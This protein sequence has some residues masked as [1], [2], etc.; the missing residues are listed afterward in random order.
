VDALR[1][2][3]STRLTKPLSGLSRANKSRGYF[4]WRNDEVRRACILARR[5]MK[6]LAFAERE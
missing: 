6:Q 1:E 4:I 5:I 3:P 2:D